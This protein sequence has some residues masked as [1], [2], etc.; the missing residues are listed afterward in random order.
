MKRE[1]LAQADG[2]TSSF[3]G[4]SEQYRDEILVQQTKR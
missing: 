3:R 1:Q 2:T 4:L